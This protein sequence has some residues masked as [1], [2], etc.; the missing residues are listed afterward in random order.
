[1]AR[2]QVQ[3]LDLLPGRG[4]V[5]GEIHDLDRFAGALR[6]RF[7]PQGLELIVLRRVKRSG[8]RIAEQRDT[9]GV[10]R[11]GARVC[12][13]GHALAVG[14]HEQRA[15]VHVVEALGQVG[16]VDIAHDGVQAQDARFAARAV[17]GAQYQFQR[18]K[19]EQDR[20]ADQHDGYGGAAQARHGWIRTGQGC[21]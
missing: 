1:M 3:H 19:K 7:F 14:G 11:L 2:A 5:D 21:T 10:G 16:A 4:A 20:T 12:A 15:L 18:E 8:D 13:V 6:Q 17:H 9:N